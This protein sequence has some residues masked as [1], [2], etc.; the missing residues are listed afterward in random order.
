MGEREEA[1][2]L[3]THLRT[4]FKKH[5]QMSFQEF[6]EFAKIE[7]LKV[8]SEYIVPYTPIEV[9]EVNTDFRTYQATNVEEHTRGLEQA[10]LHDPNAIATYRRSQYQNQ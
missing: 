3:S 7:F 10:D 6:I 2:V 9:P 1:R 5:P 8:Q 4:Y